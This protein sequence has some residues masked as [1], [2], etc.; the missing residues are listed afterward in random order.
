LT[1]KWLRVNIYLILLG[2]QK[3]VDMTQET[4]TS[5]YQILPALE[6]QIN[7]NTFYVDPDT[8]IEIDLNH[9]SQIASHLTSYLR[10]YRWHRECRRGL[11]RVLKRLS[12]S[13]LMGK[14]H[15]EAYLREKHR[16]RLRP[17]TINNSF[18]AID[19]F[20]SFI[21][22]QGKVHLEEITRQDIEGWIERQ[23]DRGV[24]AS[25][26]DTRLGML[27]A[28][29]RYLI[30]RDVLPMDLL[31]RKISIKVP[32]A[33]PRAMDPDD[34][35][36][37]IGALEGVRDRAIILVLLRTA[38][39]VGEMLNTVV[40]DVNLKERRIE[41]Y[42]AEKTRVGRVVYLS[43]DAMKALEAWIKVRD[44]YKTY[45]FY[46]QGKNRHSISYQAVRAIFAKHL[47][48]AGISHKGYTIHCLRHTCATELL[49]AGMRLE[50]VQQLL[51][52]SSVEMTRRYARLTDRTREEE[53][54]KA[55]AIIE[56]G[57]DNGDYKLDSELSA[58][59][60][61]TQLLP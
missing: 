35:R 37:I 22:K 9:Q 3:E 34:V 40:E 43:D 58:F 23:E 56:R 45:L 28:F 14:D 19:S 11:D 12:E 8:G 6:P 7:S 29:L 60:E 59:L 52:H 25:T 21:K 30:E 61:K 47:E 17:T 32:D 4:I 20:I 46:S 42:E 36:Q 18:L 57:E 48:K 51:G 5:N 10:N 39:R 27:K 49:N 2:K 38:M 26:L 13:D 55:M 41:I 31:I 33:L 50:C 16:R 24:K 53:Y 1:L 44:P 54:F 15:I